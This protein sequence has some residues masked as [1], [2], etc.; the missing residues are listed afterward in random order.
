M[1]TL[2]IAG[3]E[4]NGTTCEQLSTYDCIIAA[5]SGLEHAEA[6]GIKV[7]H[8]VG[9]FDSAAPDVVARAVAA[10]V[11]IDRFPTEKDAT[12]LEI[13]LDTASTKG[14]T[15]IEVIGIGGGRLDHLLGN[16]ML[17]ANP[18]YRRAKVSF[19]D[20][21]TVGY[22]VH[23]TLELEG[24]A[25]DLISLIPIGGP[26]RNVTLKGF[27]YPLSNEVLPVNTGRGISNEFAGGPASIEVLNGTLLAIRP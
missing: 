19:I 14:A 6:L 21:T 20:G 27:A 22:V 15:F 12:D 5:D 17:L 7:D 2:V 1:R 26:A 23:D 13:A 25:G 16:M 3:G 4:L 18:S 9:D 8:A 10:G 24:E 11:P